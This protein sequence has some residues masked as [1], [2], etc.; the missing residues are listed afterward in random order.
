[1]F[2]EEFMQEA[3]LDSEFSQIFTLLG[4]TSF[5]HTSERGCCLLTLEFLCTL[6]SSNDGVTFRLFCQEHNLSWRRLNN[7]LGFADGCALDLDSSLEDFDRLHLWTDVTRKE[8]AHKPRT[9]DIQHPTL[10]FFHKWIS[11]VLFPRNDNISVRVG[12][13]QLIYAA[14]KRQVVSPIKMPVEHWLSFSNLVGDVG[15]TSL[16][17]WIADDLGI[18]GDANIINID[19]TCEIIGYDYFCQGRWVKKIQEKLHYIHNKSALTM[20]FRQ[21]RVLFIHWFRL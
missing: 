15:C 16:I 13:M 6:K 20:N 3:G 18:L 1:M 21:P 19:T 8:N 14:L 4:W 5:Y 17:T 7:A 12:D 11:L 2:S 10:R 9:N